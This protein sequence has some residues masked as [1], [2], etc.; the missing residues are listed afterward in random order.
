VLQFNEKISPPA[1]AG[2]EMTA[3]LGYLRYMAFSGGHEVR[4]RK[5]EV[6]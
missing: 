2:V 6:G 5:N 1:F 4:G 3:V